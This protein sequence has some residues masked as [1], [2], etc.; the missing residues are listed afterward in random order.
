MHTPVRLDRQH[1]DGKAMR[2][3]DVIAPSSAAEID[4]VMR[5]DHEPVVLS[6]R[7]LHDRPRIAV[8][9]PLVAHAPM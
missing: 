1:A 3:N 6:A 9:F 2:T 8:F 5:I 7:D 4:H